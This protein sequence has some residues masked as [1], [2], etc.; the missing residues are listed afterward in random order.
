[1]VSGKQALE[2]QLSFLPPVPSGD[3]HKLPINDLP[4]QIRPKPCKTDSPSSGGRGEG[5]GGGGRGGR[6]DA[7]KV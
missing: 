2:E 3:W 6:G 7:W 5:G 4:L 1:M